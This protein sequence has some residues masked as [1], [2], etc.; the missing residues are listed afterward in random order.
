[1][2][3]SYSRQFPFFKL[4][5]NYYIFLYLY[6]WNL[7]VFSF[8]ISNFD[9]LIIPEFIVWNINGLY[10]TFGCKDTRIGKLTFFSWQSCLH[11][12]F[13]RSCFGMHQG[14]WNRRARSTIWLCMLR[15]RYFI[16]I[17]NIQN[18]IIVYAVI[19]H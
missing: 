15:R 5:K 18:R 6:L 14:V 16:W 13:N 12:I 4:R 3:I 19:V 1:M 10:S 9:Y 11:Y 17:R 7:M 2:P 8:N